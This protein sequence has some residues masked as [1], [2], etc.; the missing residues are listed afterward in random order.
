M[1]KRL[2]ISARA[3]LQR[4]DVYLAAE[5]GLTRSQA[6]ALIKRQAVTVND[7][8]ERPSY[9]VQAGDHLTV[10]QSEPSSPS[11]PAAPDLPIIYQ[12]DDLLVIDKPAGLATHPGAGSKS[13]ATVADFALLHTTD[14]D[15]DRPGIVH[16]LDRDT[17]GL[18]I[19]AKTAAAKAALQDQFRHHTIRKTYTLLVTGR[20]QSDQAVIDLPLGRDSANPLRQAVTPAGRSASTS[21]NVVATYP[22]YSLIEARPTTGRTHQLRVHFAHLGHAIAGD[23]TYGP[24]R[25]PLGLQRQFLHAAALDFIAPSG[26]H[27]QLTSPLPADLAAVLRSLEDQAS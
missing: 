17:S 23:T 11:R 13:V 2:I 9:Q 21:Y 25:R 7:L 16:R 19:I 5:L 24:V 1:T 20:P 26:T 6:Q 3:A 4:L 27:L 14:P 8:H 10:D 15:P 22:G 18:L 12:D